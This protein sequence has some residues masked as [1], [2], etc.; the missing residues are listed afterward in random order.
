MQQP[1]NLAVLRWLTWPIT[2]S[3][4]RNSFSLLASLLSLVNLFTAMVFPS[5][6]SPLYTSEYPPRPTILSETQSKTNSNKIS[7]SWR[8]FGFFLSVKVICIGF[9]TWMEFICSIHDFLVAEAPQQRLFDFFAI[10]SFPEW[11][12]K[13]REDKLAG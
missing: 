6:R 3:S 12:S 7:K 2:P 5:E 10:V 1:T 9:F 4:M 11:R 8:P 13:E